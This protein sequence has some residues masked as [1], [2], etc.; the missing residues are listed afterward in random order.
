MNTRS[1]TKSVLTLAVVAVVALAFTTSADAALIGVNAED[2]SS[3]TATVIASLGADFDPALDDVG[4][5]LGDEY[6]TSESTAQGDSPGTAARVASYE[7]T[8][9][10]ADT[11]DLYGR[12]Y[13]GPG[14]TNDDSMFYGN[15]FG[16]KSPTDDADWIKVNSHYD[17]VANQQ[18]VWINLSED[19]GSGGETGTTFTVPGGSLTQTFQIGGRE[20]GFRIDAFAFGT[21][22]ETFTDAQLSGAVAPEPAT[23]SLL[24]LG[25]LGLLRRR[26]RK[27]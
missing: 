9:N 16:S 2:G 8:F 27:A 25:G 15:G 7:V 12:V 18:Y 17:E 19:T 6:I 4:N 5:A 20:D 23:M 10:A 14:G 26:R 3:V 1:R 22:T 11:Y 24:A 21:S 13:V